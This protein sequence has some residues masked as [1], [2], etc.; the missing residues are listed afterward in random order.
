VHPPA[1]VQRAP[2]T[3][4]P[5]RQTRDLR[6][7]RRVQ[8]VTTKLTDSLGRECS[9]KIHLEPLVLRDARGEVPAAAVSASGCVDTNDIR[10]SSRTWTDRK[11]TEAAVVTSDRSDHGRARYKRVIEFYVIIHTLQMICIWLEDQ[12]IHCAPYNKLLV[13]IYRPRWRGCARA[14][15]DRQ[16]VWWSGVDAAIAGHR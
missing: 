2:R 16:G 7:G 11:A 15:G 6:D 1:T 3:T 8:Q 12:E 5:V 9:G 14:A 10:S 4:F 13:S